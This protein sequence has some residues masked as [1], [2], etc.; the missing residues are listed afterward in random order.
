MTKKTDIR[1][2]D[3][4]GAKARLLQ[5][6]TDEFATHGIAGARIDRIA[7]VARV[8][9][10]QI[11]SYYGN[12]E[13]L[14][15]LVLDTHVARILDQVPFT[16]ENLPSYAGQLFDYLIIN[17]HQVRLTT[18]NHLERD[19]AHRVTLG[20]AASIKRKIEQITEAQAQGKLP[21]RFAPEDLLAFVMGLVLA[22]V[23][24]FPVLL[25]DPKRNDLPLRRKAI[26]DAVALL[27]QQAVY[28]TE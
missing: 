12:K 9:K 10:A 23:P 1:V 6:A 11:Y 2:R 24:V 5:A 19:G 18:W 28:P 21:T 3:P 15:D 16:V 26:R 27:T 25:S 17:P 13:Q 20:L 22:W 14:F 8:N 4:E 7:R